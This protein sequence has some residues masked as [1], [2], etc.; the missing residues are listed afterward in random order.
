VQSQGWNILQTSS[1]SHLVYVAKIG[2]TVGLNGQLKLHIDSDFPEQ[3]SKNSTFQ[4]NKKNTLI[5]ENFNKKNNTIKFIGFDTI[6]DAKK[7]INQQLY[8]TIQD[9]KNN[10]TLKDDQYFWFD[11]IDCKIIEDGKVLGKIIQI[12]RYPQSDYF[13]IETNKNLVE[14]QSLPKIFLLPYI[15][16][17]ILVVD[18]K[19]KS[20][21]VQGAF[22]ILE[23]S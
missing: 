22:D 20:I 1:A 14:E 21:I 11:L 15:S 8:S 7:L 3:F 12:H 5:V 2:K 17:Y 18:T 13:E 23:A 4:T 16:S 19:D 9:T 10:C 6:E